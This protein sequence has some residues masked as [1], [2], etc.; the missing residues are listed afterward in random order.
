MEFF[1]RQIQ[2]TPTTP[3]WQRFAG[4]IGLQVGCYKNRPPN[5]AKCGGGFSDGKLQWK[6]RK[7]GCISGKPGC[8]TGCRK[9]TE[10]AKWPDWRISLS[11]RKGR[12]GTHGETHRRNRVSLRRRLPVKTPSRFVLRAHTQKKERSFV[13]TRLYRH[14]FGRTTASVRGLNDNFWVF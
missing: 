13:Q 12:Q 11:P 4:W 8:C 1:R 10:P 14:F 5:V 6:C 9:E 2:K 3:F 7:C